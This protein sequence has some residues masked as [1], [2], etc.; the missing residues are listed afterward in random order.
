MDR[1]GGRLD[2]IDRGAVLLG[3][4]IISMDITMDRSRKDK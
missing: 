3:W 4:G 1:S 2:N